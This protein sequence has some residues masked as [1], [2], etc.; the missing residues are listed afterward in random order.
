[1][2]GS[3][4]VGGVSVYARGGSWA[5]LV[6]GPRDPLTGDRH[7]AYRGG[8]EAPMKP[9]ARRRTPRSAWTRALRL[10]PNEFTCKPSSLNGWN[11]HAH[12]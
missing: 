11:P 8:F 3:R 4:K 6:E 5:Y 7:R 9:G 1:M 10:T 2:T 12:R